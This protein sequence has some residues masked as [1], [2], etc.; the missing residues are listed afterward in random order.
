MST[1]KTQEYLGD[2]VYAEIDGG[3][4]ILLKANSPDNPSGIIYLEPAVMER[5]IRYAKRWKIIE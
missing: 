4:Q 2:G 3:F 5:L 1:E